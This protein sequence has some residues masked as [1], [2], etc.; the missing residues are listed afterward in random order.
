MK[1][2]LATAPKRP[3]VVVLGFRSVFLTEPDYRTQGRYRRRIDYFATQDEPLLDELAYF[4][5]LGPAE[6]FAMRH[7]SVW[8]Q[9]EELRTATE[10]WFKDELAARVVGLEPAVLRGAV[11]RVFADENKRAEAVNAAQQQAEIIVERPHFDFP[12]QLERS[13]LP[14]IVRIAREAGI[15]LVLVRLPTRTTAENDPQSLPAWHRDW[16]PGYEAD[17][18]AWLAEQGVGALDFEGDPRIPVDWFARGD[19]LGEEPGQ[20]EFTKILAAALEPYL[21]GS[22]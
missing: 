12:A 14:E 11:E 9:R 7:W 8:Q 2:V 17:L 21:D 13:F 18:F 5:T 20:A 1:N 15:K 16:M 3:A 10:T 22:L 19:H 4:R 6:L